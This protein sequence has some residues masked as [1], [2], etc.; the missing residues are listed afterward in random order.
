MIETRWV[1]W[2]GK[3]NGDRVLINA[4]AFDPAIHSDTSWPPENDEKP[5]TEESPS[6]VPAPP[7]S[8]KKSAK[9]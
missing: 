7:K 2:K 1:Y 4:S 3:F 6:P 8:S 9:G 5:A